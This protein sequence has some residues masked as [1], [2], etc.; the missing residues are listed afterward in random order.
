MVGAISE[1]VQTLP[2][3]PITVTIERATASDGA[4]RLPTMALAGAA[5]KHNI[6]IGMEKRM[7]HCRAGL[8]RIVK[9]SSVHSV[10]RSRP[11]GSKGK[12][13]S[14]TID[15]NMSLNSSEKPGQRLSMNAEVTAS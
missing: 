2:R 7:L 10:L 4:E 14:A 3:E 9:S 11:R 8:A 5:T 13:P 12:G 6:I 1:P 15:M